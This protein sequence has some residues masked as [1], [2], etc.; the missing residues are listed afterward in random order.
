MVSNFCKLNQIPYCSTLKADKNDTCATC[1]DGYRLDR[2]DQ[3]VKNTPN[4]CGAIPA[5]LNCAIWDE[6]NN[7]CSKCTAGYILYKNTSLTPA[8]YT[9]VQA[10]GY[11]MANC[12]AKNT[13]TPT[14]TYA[15]NFPNSN[16]DYAKQYTMERQPCKRCSAGFLPM[17]MKYSC[18]TLPTITGG[19]SASIINKD[20]FTPVANC[21]VYHQKKNDDTSW[22][23][24]QCQTGYYLVLDTPSMGTVLCR[25]FKDYAT[26]STK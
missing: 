23:C 15:Y 21:A 18:I 3:A 17:Q 26:D 10:W 14:D 6:T 13:D 12:D 7:I 8:W 5:T 9:C 25:A 22:K 2:N 20:D 1:I 11:T 4:T 24:S 16:A 19:S